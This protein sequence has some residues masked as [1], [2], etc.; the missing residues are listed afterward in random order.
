MSMQTRPLSRN[1]GSDVEVVEDSEP[2]R[3][4]FRRELAGATGLLKRHGPASEISRLNGWQ[5]TS[6]VI[7]ISG[8]S[9]DRPNTSTDLYEDE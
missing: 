8:V 7:E 9:L 2:E 3:I 4:L 5:T 6:T 1:P